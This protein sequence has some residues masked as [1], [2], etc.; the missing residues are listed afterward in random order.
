MKLFFLTLVFAGASVPLLA[1]EVGYTYEKVVDEMGMPTSKMEAGASLTLNYTDSTIKLLEGKVVSIKMAGVAS[2]DP[3]E[4]VIETKGVPA[5]KIEAGSAAVLRYADATIKLR[6]GKVVS[7]KMVGAG[8]G[9]VLDANGT[10]K[11]APV[12]LGEW[13]TDYAAALRQAKTG[14]RRVLLFFT[15]SDWCG[16]CKRLDGEVL[17]TTDF[18]AYAREQLILVKLDFPRSIPQSAQVKARNKKLSEQYQV[19]GYPTIVVLD[20]NGNAVGRLGYQPGGPRLFIEELK[21][22]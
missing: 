15:G 13:T 22:F 21:K 6:E 16:W 12:G 9:L 5:S 17:A 11:P 1:V 8:E 2:D 10:S 18:R 20:S 7:I 4:K 19:D 3:Y 14:K